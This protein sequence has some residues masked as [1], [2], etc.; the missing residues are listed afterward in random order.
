MS[1]EIQHW[2]ITYSSTKMPFCTIYYMYCI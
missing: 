1:M 2:Q